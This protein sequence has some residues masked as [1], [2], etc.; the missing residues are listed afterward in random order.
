M[1]T[2]SGVVI[3]QRDLRWVQHKLDGLN[4]ARMSAGGLSPDDE[5]RYHDLCVLEGILLARLVSEPE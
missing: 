3:T 1:I 2:V 5:T 4:D